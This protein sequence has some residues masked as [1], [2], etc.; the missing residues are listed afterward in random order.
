M[1]TILAVS[2]RGLGALFFVLFAWLSVAP[3]VAW[4]KG[5]V[6]A[7]KT[8]VDEVEGNWKLSFIIDYGSMPDIQFIPV[9]IT[10][11]PVMLYE[12]SLTDESGDKPVLTRKALQNQKTI[13]VSTDISFSD[14]T[15]KMFKQTKFKIT[16]NR[17]KGFEAGEYVMKIKKAD[18]G[19]TLGSNVRLTLNGENKIVDRRSIS[20]VGESSGKKKDP[21][22]AASS[23]PPPSDKPADEPSP[24]PPNDPPPA[25]E[26]PPVPPKQGGCGCELAA[27]P[28][29]MPLSL[30]LAGLLGLFVLRRRR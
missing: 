5:S 2:R 21:P 27:G 4:A 8:A 12:R 14:G 6:K 11:E 15:G 30:A 18:G 26:P 9:L 29:R 16:L 24:P 28:E 20:F 3:S 13:D 17:S 22:P 7:E 25:E 23:E 10:F 19:E 1:T